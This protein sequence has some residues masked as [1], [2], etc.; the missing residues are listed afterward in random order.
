MINSYK[1]NLINLETFFINKYDDN[2]GEL[3]KNNINE[4]LVKFYKSEKYNS[5]KDTEFKMMKHYV[6]GTLNLKSIGG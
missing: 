3:F 6:D 4:E 5:Q 2:D 1:S